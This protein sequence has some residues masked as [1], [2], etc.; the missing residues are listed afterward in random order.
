M[1]PTATQASAW[2]AVVLVLMLLIVCFYGAGRADHLV[3]SPE[4]VAL[5]ADS[6]KLFADK[7]SLSFSEFKSS[8]S[9]IVKPDVVMYNTVRKLWR[10]NNLTP[11]AIQ[12]EVFAL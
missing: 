1:P 12:R 6:K 10:K 7:A 2:A 9:P 5:A 3:V 8:I 4:A 11:T